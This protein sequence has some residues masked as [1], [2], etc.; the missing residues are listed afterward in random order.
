MR[1][2]RLSSGSLL[3]DVA[4]CQRR[5][6]A[7]TL[8]SQWAGGVSNFNFNFH[9]LLAQKGILRTHEARRGSNCAF[10]R[11]RLYST[12]GGKKGG[13]KRAGPTAH[14]RYQATTSKGN[15]HLVHEI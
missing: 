8:P 3:C 7:E 11:E 6:D 15:E 13:I 1:S 4:I 14:G 10:S 9:R 5:R 12:R 2:I